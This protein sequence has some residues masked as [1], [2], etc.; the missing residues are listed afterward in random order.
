MTPDEYIEFKLGHGD[1]T[2]DRYENALDAKKRYIPA[3]SDD[4]Q[5]DFYYWT[6]Y[7]RAYRGNPIPRWRERLQW[8][9]DAEEE[10]TD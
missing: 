8:W 10:E 4:N 2:Q 7:C 5:R 1:G 3:S 6:G 9:H